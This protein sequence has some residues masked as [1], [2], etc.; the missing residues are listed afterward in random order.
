MKRFRIV[1][2]LVALALCSLPAWAKCPSP[3]PS[4]MKREQVV[5][6]FLEISTLRDELTQLQRLLNEKIAILQGEVRGL[7]T[8]SE[9]LI[10]AMRKPRIEIR[11]ATLMMKDVLPHVRMMK[12]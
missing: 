3:I 2:T 7:R 8:H 12:F 9:S 4:R 1:L 6:C 10:N 11:I 5:E